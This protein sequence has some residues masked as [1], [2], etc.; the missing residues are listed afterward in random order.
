MA[1]FGSFKADPLMM[2]RVATR[3]ETLAG[4][5]IPFVI[6]CG[7]GTADCGYAAASW[8]V[9]L[10]RWIMSAPTPEIQRRRTVGLLLGYN[11]D[12]IAKFED[13]ASKRCFISP[14]QSP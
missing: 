12:A 11:A 9:D 1:L 4:A 6:D 8:V 2:L 5:A 13:R 10:Y 14:A 3:L 7:D